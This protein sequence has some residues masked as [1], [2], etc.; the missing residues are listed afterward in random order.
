MILLLQGTSIDHQPQKTQRIQKTFHFIRLC[1]AFLADH[2]GKKPFSISLRNDG[3][4][5]ALD[6]PFPYTIE[7]LP[8]FLIPEKIL[9]QFLCGQLIF[10]QTKQKSLIFGVF[11]DSE[12]NSI[13][14]VGEPLI[15]VCIVSLDEIEVEVSILQ[16]EMEFREHFTAV[17]EFQAEFCLSRIV[18]LTWLSLPDR[19]F[20]KSAG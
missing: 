17:F 18:W 11:L 12:Q 10:Y 3:I 4:I 5:G 1:R 20:F 8:A 15:S 9:Y 2:F 19:M 13:V 7:F 6:K 16:C 14:Q